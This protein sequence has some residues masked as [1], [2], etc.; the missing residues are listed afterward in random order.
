M[1]VWC[2][3]AL[4]SPSRQVMGFGDTTWVGVELVLEAER[5]ETFWSTAPKAPP[6]QVGVE[7]GLPQ[8]C[9]H[10]EQGGSWHYRGCSC[11][12]EANSEG[13]VQPPNWTG[14]GGA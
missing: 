13:W 7:S 6:L 8:V 3:T 11:P 9:P 12:A 2:N 1:A 4:G 5:Q 14:E 10:T